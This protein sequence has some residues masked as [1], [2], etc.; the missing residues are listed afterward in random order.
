MVNKKICFGLIPGTRGCFN[1]SLAQEG[2]KQL[3]AQ[4]VK[5]GFD[6]VVLEDSATESSCVEDYQDAKK[7][8]ALFQE[9]RNRIDG[10]IVVL[11]N[12]G[13]EIGIVNTIQMAHLDVPVLLQASSD[14]LD[15]LGTHQRRD[16]FCGKLSVANNFY[17]YDIPFSDTSTHTCAI[18]SEAFSKDILQFA[19][20]CRTVNGLKKARIGAIGPRPIGFQTVRVSEKIL[21][22]SGIT[23]V[24][25]D[26]SEIMFAAMALKDDDPVVQEKLSGIKG[27]GTIP[28]GIPGERILRQAK[29][30]AAIEKWIQENEID[31]AAIQCWESVE[32]NYKCAV[33]ATMSM[34]GESLV[35]CACEVDIAGAISM[36][37][38]TL[39]SQ[40][41][42]ALLDWNNNYGNQPNKC[43]CTHCGNFPKSFTQNPI[44]ISNLDVL[45]T[46]LGEENCFG[47]VKGKVAAGPMTFFR[48]HTDDRSG[49]MKA[50]LGEG[51]FTDDPFSMSGGIA[52]CDVPELAKFLKFMM[53]GGFEHHVGMVRDHV[54]DV[55][56]DAIGNYMGWD[57]Y[58]HS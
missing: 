36:Y 41:A 39:A 26:S 31:A 15:K 7:C 53:K 51:K 6:Y 29:Y 44:E 58:R 24:P 34:L 28:A 14:D 35:P 17:Q 25:V 47:A 57:L 38:L 27:Y 8:A 50:Y 19:A 3:I 46:V 43:V 18:D 10:I 2:K 13:D 56:E 20:T 4:M 12:F 11:P 48:M 9:N 33:C 54:G 1:K 23:V 40:N 52:V 55:L 21:Q 45:S 5:L 49:Q 30:Y 22:T 37:A 42:S 16:A 32:K